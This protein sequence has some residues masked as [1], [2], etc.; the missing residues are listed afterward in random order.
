MKSEKI[1]FKWWVKTSSTKL[2]K[3]TVLPCDFENIILLPKK[4]E[5][6]DI[7]YDVMFCHNSFQNLGCII[8][9]H[10]NKGIKEK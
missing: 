2:A 8:W 10:Y 5:I 9:G 3:P 1:I 6:N 7:E 4:E